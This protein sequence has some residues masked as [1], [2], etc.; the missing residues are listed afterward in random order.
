MLKK[1]VFLIV[2]FF[3]LSACARRFSSRYEANPV[4]S[5][6]NNLQRIAEDWVGT[7][8]LYGGNDKRGIDCSG[9]AVNIYRQVYKKELPRSTQ[10]QRRL[11]YS[12]GAGYVRPGDLLFFRMK[13]Y[14]P[15]NHVG[16]YLGRGRFIHAS[17]SRGVVISSL[18]DPFYQRHL[19]TARRIRK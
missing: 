15:L 7:P 8:Y 5:Q 11:G 13:K 9:L 12:V 18:D 14:E 17:S 16:V 10:Q 3:L 1:T 4:H 19:V 6:E 2:V